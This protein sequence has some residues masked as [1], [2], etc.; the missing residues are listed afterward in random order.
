M[1]WILSCTHL[2]VLLHLTILAILCI[3]SPH[4]TS[5]IVEELGSR[6]QTVGLNFTELLSD[7]FVNSNPDCFISKLMLLLWYLSHIFL[8]PFTDWEW[9]YLKET[10]STKFENMCWLLQSTSNVGPAYKVMSSWCSV[11]WEL[12]RSLK[13]LSYWITSN[14]VVISW[15]QR[16]NFSEASPC[17]TWTNE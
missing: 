10:D 17:V 8:P 1:Y 14:F 9:G 3:L 6:R 13:L 15:G 7:H 5:S 12:C 2:H 16:L 4:P 11:S